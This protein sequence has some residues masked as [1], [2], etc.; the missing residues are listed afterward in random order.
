MLW[1]DATPTAAKCNKKRPATLPSE[2][3]L[4]KRGSQGGKW[5]QWQGHFQDRAH[6]QGAGAAEEPQVCRAGD[7]G[8][9][10]VRHALL[11]LVSHDKTQQDQSSKSAE[12]EPIGSLK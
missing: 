3:Q 11:E 6:Q 5:G 1:G 7:C 12:L 2:C 8:E 10:E 4:R 9:L